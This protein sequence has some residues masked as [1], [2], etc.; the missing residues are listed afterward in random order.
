MRPNESW[1]PA[2][3]GP[4]RKAAS[5]PIVSWAWPPPFVGMLAEANHQKDSSGNVPP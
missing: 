5:R 1:L 2:A 4:F 3:T